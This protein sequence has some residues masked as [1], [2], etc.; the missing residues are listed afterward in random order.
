MMNF[1]S[2][3]K[4]SFKNGD[5]K[6][7]LSKVKKFMLS[8]FKIDLDQFIKNEDNHLDKIFIK[9]G[10]DKGSKDSKKT[11]D[12]LFRN[13]KN[14]IYK[15]YFDWIKRDPNE[16]FK[17]QLGL[18]SAPLY[19]KIFAPRRKEK[20][21]ILEIGVANG[22]SIAS[23]C[24]Y[25]PNGQIYGIDKKNK[26][27]F[28]YKSKKIK[29]FE[30]DIFNKKKVETFIKKFGSFDYIIDDS[31]HEESAI[32]LNL[33]NFFPALKK[34][35]VYFVEDFKAIDQ[36]RE[37]VRAYQ[38]KNNAPYFVASTYTIKESLELI[39]NNIY[40]ESPFLDKSTLEYLHNNLSKLHITNPE[41]ENPPGHPLASIAV[42]TKKN[43]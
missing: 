36:Y 25:F 1:I 3:L 22:H 9:Y 31:L 38:K 26:S 39:Q 23:W 10:T 41:L 37:K 40:F 17:Y 2:K 6:T 33:K 14:S 28:F 34:N 19:D 11:Y 4:K 18:N 42:L 5:L 20:V 8:D 29:Y 30:L 35:G 13:K 32:F 21:K 7:I 27:F 43:T 15:N 24:E 12:F 16:E